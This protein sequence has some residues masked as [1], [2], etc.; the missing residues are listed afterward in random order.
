MQKVSLMLMVVVFSTF[1]TTFSHTRIHDKHTHK[2]VTFFQWD[3]GRVK[4]LP[5][6]E[7]RKRRRQKKLQ[8]VNQFS[9]LTQLEM[10]QMKFCALVRIFFRFQPSLHW[11]PVFSGIFLANE[12]LG[13]L[14]ARAGSYISLESFLVLREKETHEHKPTANIACDINEGK[15]KIKSNSCVRFARSALAAVSREFS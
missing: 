8:N 7:N 9:I 13:P 1:F 5:P 11:C 12:T 14:L 10:S 4:C 15:R 2:H 3:A 6:I